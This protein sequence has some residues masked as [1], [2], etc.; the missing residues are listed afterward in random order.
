VLLMLKIIP[1]CAQLPQ[2]SQYMFSGLVIN[3]AYAGTEEALSITFIQRKQWVG[4]EQSPSTQTLSAHTLFKNNNLGL[5]FTMINDRVGVH[6]H[7]SAL[8]VV[9]YH[10]RLAG[11][12]VVSMGL[13]AGIHHQKSDYTP[14]NGAQNDPKLAN[15]FYA[16]TFMDFGTGLYLRSKTLHLGVSVLEL[17]RKQLR[18]GDHSSI[19]F[20]RVH[21][22]F[23][24]KYRYV[25]G[26]TVAFEPSVLLKYHP[27]LPLS[28]DVNSSFILHEVLT[29]GLSYRKAE[30]V[31]FLLKAQV[32]PQLQVG[33]AYDYTLQHLR[34]LSS[35]SHELMVSYLFK[36][37]KNN[38]TSP[39]R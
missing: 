5:G 24:G 32:T 39:R 7:L 36:Y 20:K 9:S 27:G 18:S 13:Q 15:T 1:C 31:D 8:P 21:Y 22:N 3:P 4:V 35:G 30:S 28:Y 14:L 19:A 17:S 38:I 16:G 6:R 34:R 10:I 26:Q 11:E 12:T 29:V 37:V 23:F 2:L 25:L 33:Y